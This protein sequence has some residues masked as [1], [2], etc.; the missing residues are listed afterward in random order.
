MKA[1]RLLTLVLSSVFL[2]G[3]SLACVEASAHDGVGPKHKQGY[4][5]PKGQHHMHG[6]KKGP[7]HPHFRAHRFAKHPPVIHY[8][9]HPKPHGKGYTR[10]HKGSRIVI[11][12]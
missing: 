6:H 8:H 5:M 2:V 7:K 9:K 12:L 11:T 3:T 1:S 10:L 4:V